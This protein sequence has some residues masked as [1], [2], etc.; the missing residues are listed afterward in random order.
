[1]AVSVHQ[2]V[3]CSAVVQCSSSVVSVIA[4]NAYTYGSG[5][6]RWRVLQSKQLQTTLLLAK[7]LKSLISAFENFSTIAGINTFRKE[8][9]IFVQVSISSRLLQMSYT[10]F[11]QHLGGLVQMTRILSWVSIFQFLLPSDISYS[12]N[13]LI[14][15]KGLYDF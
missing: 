9:V 14:I 10:D 8:Y 15:N 3:Q 1:M 2:S 5:F 7:L 6:P 4:K 13:F 11:Q 12:H